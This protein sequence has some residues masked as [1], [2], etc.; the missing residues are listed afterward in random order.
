ME[1]AEEVLRLY[2]EKYSNLNVRHFHEKLWEEHGIGLSY[3]WVKPALQ[4]FL[5]S[6]Q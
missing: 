4:G 1:V 5:P 3:T 6:D 2:Q